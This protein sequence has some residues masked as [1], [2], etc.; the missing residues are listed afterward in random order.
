MNM[1]M[2][3]RYVYDVGRR[4]PAKQRED[5]EKELKSLLMDNI[6]A[7]TAGREPT[8]DDVAAVIKEFGEP[9]D[10]AARY[11]GERYVVGPKLYS[12][13]RFVLLLALG[14]V[15]LALF[16]SVFTIPLVQ[17]GSVRSVG[18]LLLQYL[19]TLIP[20]VWGTIGIVTLIFWGIER[21]IT[22]SAGKLPD[23]IA[24]WD[25]RQLPPVPKNKHPWK[26][27]DSIAAIVFTVIALIVFN[28]YPN[29]IAVY[30]HDA[31]GQWQ[32]VPVLSQA[33]LAAF[34]PL[35]NIGWALALAMHTVVLAQGRWR[36]GT[37]LAN[38]AVQIYSIA[39][40]AV[41]MAGPALL[42]A[43]ISIA[44]DANAV[45]TFNTV[46]SVLRSLFYW[47][48][49]LAI[50]GC[51]VELIKTVIRMVREGDYSGKISG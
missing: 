43:G 49:V 36:L 13:Y 33:A 6:E 42:N 5:I 35:W 30:S 27:A 22:S 10:V 50:F 4:L 47:I 3:D 40:V 28:A 18:G 20:T 19:G 34:L 15:A 45:D 24:A 8:Q 11:S 25:P 16:I 7:K 23:K 9:A 46:I 31:S 14:A 12:A 51:V 48:Y 1:E 37:N 32:R 38:I 17:P 29:L 41:M 26:P 39:V 21:G 2:L 44:G